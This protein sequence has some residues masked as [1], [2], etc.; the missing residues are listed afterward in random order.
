[1][2]R[3]DNSWTLWYNQDEERPG[4]GPGMGWMETEDMIQKRF[5]LLYAEMIAAQEAWKRDKSLRSRVDIAQA[6]M[7]NFVHEHRLVR[8]PE[9]IVFY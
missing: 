1:M 3:L 2:E 9:W 5:D 6:T 7:R 4:M 8:R